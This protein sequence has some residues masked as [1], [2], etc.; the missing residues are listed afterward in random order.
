[1]HFSQPDSSTREQD[2]ALADLTDNATA[3]DGVESIILHDI[4]QA[5]HMLISLSASAK[6]SPS[7]QVERKAI[8]DAIHELELK[9]HCSLQQIATN[10]EYQRWEE[11][12]ASCFYTAVQLY[13][14]ITVRKLPPAAK[15][16]RELVY[17]LST[18]IEEASF[19]IDLFILNDWADLWSWIHSIAASL[20]LVH[21]DAIPTNTELSGFIYEPILST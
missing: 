19:C 1:M 7:S 3:R 21:G 13:L 9:T 11:H 5:L 14:C 4:N 12:L 20:E 8:S 17:R 15:I 2:E 16:V 18:K 6:I 10:G